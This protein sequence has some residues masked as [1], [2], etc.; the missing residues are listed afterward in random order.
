MTAIQG[1]GR[2]LLIEGK[3]TVETAAEALRALTPEQL[4][5]LAS[6]Y[7]IPTALTTQGTVSAIL[8]S[9]RVQVSIIL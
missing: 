8:A 2:K 6:E 7:G 3:L 9:G 5:T 4:A 1:N